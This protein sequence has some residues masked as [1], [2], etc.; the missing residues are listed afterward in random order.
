MRDSK[1]RWSRS[2][3]TKPLFVFGRSTTSVKSV[4]SCSSGREHFRKHRL[5]LSYPHDVSTRSCHDLNC[6]R[7][8]FPTR[9]MDAFIMNRLASSKQAELRRKRP[10]RYE[11]RSC[12][13]HAS[14]LLQRVQSAC[15]KLKHRL[16]LSPADPDVFSSQFR[17]L[18][19]LSV[20]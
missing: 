18:P 8:M 15:A 20:M 16:C 6:T 11:C 19:P 4:L 2:E 5:R 9:S 17:K 12:A 14:S 10:E 3:W 13:R 1:R 7:R